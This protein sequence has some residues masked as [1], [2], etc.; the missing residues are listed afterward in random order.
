MDGSDN[1][2]GMNR[3]H[4]INK[5]LLKFATMPIDDNWQLSPVRGRGDAR[6]LHRARERIDARNV[7]KPYRNYPWGLGRGCTV[8]RVD[9]SA[10]PTRPGCHVP[11]AEE[12]T[13]APSEDDEGESA[14]DIVLGTIM[15][16][17]PTEY[18]ED[19]GHE[20]EVESVVPS[21]PT[22]EHVERITWRTPPSRFN[23]T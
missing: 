18:C 1:L 16:P 6:A 17:P 3:A 13:S 23:I 22:T 21:H 19:F 11:P 9:R 20:W 7:A 15:P 5:N 4:D 14:Y 12:T 2:F 8:E 10:P